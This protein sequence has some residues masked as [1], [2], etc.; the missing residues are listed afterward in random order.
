MHRLS[1]SCSGCP[2]G[3]KSNEGQSKGRAFFLPSVPRCSPAQFP[4]RV[5]LQLCLLSSPCP[6]LLVPFDSLVSSCPIP[7]RLSSLCPHSLH[8]CPEPYWV[9]SLSNSIT[10]RLGSSSPGQFQA[11]SCRKP[12]YSL[13]QSELSASS[14]TPSSTGPCQASVPLSHRPF[15]HSDKELFWWGLGVATKEHVLVARVCGSTQQAK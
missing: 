6:S 4:Q 1:R 7:D 13:D 5:W 15:Y 11:A 14:L 12:P 9:P 8:L 2:L 10:Y 3:T